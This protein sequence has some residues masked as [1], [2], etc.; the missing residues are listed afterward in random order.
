[1]TNAAGGNSILIFDR[2]ANGALTSAGSAAT[3]GAGTGSGLGSQGSL[4]LTNDQRWLLA[5]NARSNDVTVFSVTPGGLQWRSRMPSGGAMPITI[6]IHGRLIYVLNAG[7][8]NLSGFHL[9]SDGT[10]TGVRH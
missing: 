8:P 4:V 10:L 1:M 5:A 2:A 9:S 6:A 7:T 3:G